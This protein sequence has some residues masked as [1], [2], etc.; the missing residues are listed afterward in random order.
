MCFL[1]SMSLA[2]CSLATGVCET[3]PVWHPMVLVGMLSA[4]MQR[5]A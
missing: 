2:S 4:M 3:P 1:C 5:A